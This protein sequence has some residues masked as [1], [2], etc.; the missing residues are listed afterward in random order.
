[1]AGMAI[2]LTGVRSTTASS[3]G[4]MSGQIGTRSTPAGKFVCVCACMV[5]AGWGWGV[6]VGGV[7]A[8]QEQGCV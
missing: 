8:Q 1:M 2:L 6:G 3:S 5:G 7:K 4:Q